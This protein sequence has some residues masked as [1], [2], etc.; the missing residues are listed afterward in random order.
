[1]RIES[2]DLEARRCVS[3]PH[4]AEASTIAGRVPAARAQGLSNPNSLDAEPPLARGVVGVSA[5]IK[6]GDPC[7]EL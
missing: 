4:V 2:L 7:G 3:R 5:S 1:M 6:P